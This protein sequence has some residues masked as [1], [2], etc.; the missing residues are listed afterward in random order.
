MIRFGTDG[1]RAIIAKDFTFD[2]VNCVTQ[3]T[4]R[5]IQHDSITNNG[6]VIGHDARFLGREFSEHCACTFAEMGIPVKIAKTIAPT[7]AVSWGALAFDAV[8]IVITASHNP[9]AYNG[10]K[11]KAPFGGPAT[12]DQIA[13]VESHLPSINT[14]LPLKS[15]DHYVA[16]GLIQEINLVD[17]YIK[18][19]ESKFDLDAI[20][21]SEIK[22][23]HDAMYG[24]GMG[25]VERMLPGQVVPLHAE[26][27]PGFHGQAPEPIERN[28]PDLPKA[29]LEHGCA[30]GL[31]NDGDADRIGMVDERG[32]FVDSHQMLSLLTWYQSQ[33]KGL[34]GDVIKT[35]STTTMLDKMAEKYG[36]GFETRP[37]GFKHV[38]ERI[39]SGDV[40][41]GGEES[42]GLAVKGHIPERDGLYIGLLITEMVVTSGKSL[43]ELI[44]GLFDEFGLHATWREDLHTQ[45]NLKQAMMDACKAKKVTQIAG[46]KVVEWD[47][48]DGVKHIMEDGSWL[49][50]RPS[51]TEPV[52]RIYS[53]SSTH[54]RAQALVKETVAMVDHPPS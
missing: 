25:L 27:N 40:I 11:I 13:A 49:L 18:D 24:A 15:F 46:L 39:I 7:P 54:E 4:A 19:L 52:L 16:N 2:N 1:W 31:A 42:G 9:P 10:F 21:K 50:V 43:S 6:V 5:W 45:E 37:I 36:L 38:A 33:V 34:K 3:A 30:V 22:I 47:M 41:V 8:G 35:F 28:L 20:R 17:Q 32:V 14:P 12:P 23:A 48:L 44:Q 51:G 29:V 53:E 26:V